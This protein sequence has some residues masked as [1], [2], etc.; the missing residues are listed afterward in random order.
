MAQFYPKTGNAL[1]HA[2]EISLTDLANFLQTDKGT[3]GR[4]H[5][6]WAPSFPQHASWYYTPVYE[7]Y[8]DPVRDR[9]NIKFMEIGICDQRFPFASPK[10]WLQYF[11]NIDLYSID[12]FWGNSFTQDSIAEI[13]NMGTNFIYAD[14]GSAEDWDFIV[15]TIGK[16]SLDFLVEDG[17]HY[18]HHVMYSLYR[19]IDLLKPG[20]YYFMEDIQNPVKSRN[21]YGYDNADILLE[22]QN[23]DS[24]YRSSYISQEMAN[25][26]KSHYELVEISADPN[27]IN[28]LIVFKKL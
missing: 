24:N 22:F 14:Q 21:W 18:P 4:E 13:L 1:K 25:S 23:W 7:K 28:Y 16:N 9:K 15:D 10:M 6:S 12:N 5:L 26:I 27:E 11:K 2:P 3:L 20:G 17:S 8:M 19:S